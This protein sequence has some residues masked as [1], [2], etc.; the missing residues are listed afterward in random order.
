M[1]L[2]YLSELCAFISKKYN[3]EIVWKDAEESIDDDDS[4]STIAVK[5]IGITKLKV[6][7][8]VNAANDGLW[9]GAESVVPYSAKQDHL[10]LQRLVQLLEDVKQ[11]MLS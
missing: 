9:E 1:N 7:A 11:E 5:K 6:D 8:I 10:N 3:R 2:D 4:S